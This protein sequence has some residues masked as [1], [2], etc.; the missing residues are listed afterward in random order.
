M[1]A[2]PNP[3]STFSMAAGYA[4]CRP[5]VHPRVIEFVRSSLGQNGVFERALDVGCGAGLS[6]KAL[7]GFAEHCIGL[8]PA[9]DMLRQAW[10][11]AQNATFVVGRAEAIPVRE[12]TVDVITAA[13]SLNYTDLDLFFPEAA[14]VLKPAGAIVVYDFRTGQ[15]FRESQVLDD[16]F[17]KF[18]DR[19]P[20]PENEAREVNPEIL[21]RLDSGFAVTNH[22]YFEIGLT[23]TS[24]FYLDYMLT[25]TNVAFALRRGVALDEIRSWCIDTLGPIWDGK[26]REV[27]FFGYFACMR[28]V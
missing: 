10:K 8:E 12:N 7:D 16:W 18:V 21:S 3:F 13:G 11:I 14:R 6:T 4:T 25:E 19:Y 9:E 15:T 17:A 22:E 24:E 2:V 1:T 26:E 27:L 23:L 5:P 20:W 28:A